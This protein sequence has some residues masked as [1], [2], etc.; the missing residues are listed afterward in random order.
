MLSQG[1][2]TKRKRS[3]FA[4]L[5]RLVLSMGLIGAL[6]WL[7]ST[8]LLRNGSLSKQAVQVALTRHLAVIRKKIADL[9]VRLR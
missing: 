9:K 6:A 1:P 3:R 8:Y 2:V 7:L 5:G 4:L